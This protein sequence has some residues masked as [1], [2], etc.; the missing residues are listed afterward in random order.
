[1]YFYYPQI[2]IRSWGGGARKGTEGRSDRLE[3]AQWWSE[4]GVLWMQ[5]E[6]I[7]AVTNARKLAKPGV[8]CL[9]FG[10][11]DLTFSIE[12]YPHHTFKTVDDGVRHVCEQLADTSVAVCYRNGSPDTREKYAE[13]GVTVFLEY[14]TS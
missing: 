6:S 5:I 13:M 9:S 3:Y 11:A 14:P 4:Y 10:P 8:D 1:A 7:P 2:G 12:A